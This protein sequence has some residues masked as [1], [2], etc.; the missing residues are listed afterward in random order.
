MFKNKTSLIFFFFLV[1]VTFSYSQEGTKT[2]DSLAI[3]IS[4]LNDGPYVFIEENQ[5]IEKNIINGEVIT[6]TLKSDAFDTEFPPDQ[7]VFNDIKKIA[8]FSDLHGQYDLGVELLKNNNII[9]ENGNWDFGK[10]HL[11]IVGDVFDRGPKVNEILWL[12]FKLEQQAIKQGGRVHYLLGNHEYMVL[13][14]DNRYIHKNYVLSS[15]V[16]EKEYQELYDNNTVLGRWLRSK[17]T[18]VQIN[19]NVFVHGGVSK[20]FISKNDFTLEKI[21]AIMRSSIERTKEEMKI[22]DFY[23]T[24]YGKKSLI[25]YRGYFNDDLKEEEIDEILDLMDIEHVVVGHCSN[26]KVVQLYHQKIF[27]VDSS[28]K[29]GKYGEILWIKNDH[30]SRRTLEGKKKE[31]KEKE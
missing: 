31:F 7:V 17:N 4:K 16:L 28:I 9:D 19:E 8:A 12:I 18:I 13:H 3:A 30:Y 23:K 29:K 24:Y 20:K 25:W 15:K 1:I 2:T 14:G 11:V 6:K 27:G 21:N 26:K 22:T 10:G 5:L